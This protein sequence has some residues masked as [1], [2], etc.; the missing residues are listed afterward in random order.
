MIFPEPLTALAAVPAAA[1]LALGED[2]ARR[3]QVRHAA[4]PQDGLYLLA[5]EDGIRQE[6][7]HI[8]EIPVA[9]ALVEV[10]AADGRQARGGAVLMGASVELATAAAVCDA[11]LRA[12]FA[13]ADAVAT[14]VEQGRVVQARTARERAVQRTATRV[15]FADLADGGGA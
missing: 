11:V 9:S 8:G 13:G 6:P 14:L 15:D 2:L 10:S 7:W 1:V 4:V 12:G 5:L 3:H